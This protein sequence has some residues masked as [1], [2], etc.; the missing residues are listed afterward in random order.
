MK[1]AR[2]LFFL[3][4]GVLAVLSLPGCSTHTCTT[5]TPGSTGSGGGT[6]SGALG[7]H[8]CSGGGGV[9]GGIGVGSALIYVVNGSTASAATLSGNT[10]GLVSPFTP[11]TLSGSGADDMFIVNKKFLYIPQAGS[12]T[13]EGFVISRSSGALTPITGSPFSVPSG[14]DTIASDPQGRFLFVG[15][16]GSGQIATFM[17]DPTTGALTQSPGSPFTYGV[18]SADT[19]AVDGN[20][21]FLYVGQM[22]SAMPLH[23]FSIDQNTGAI[24][25]ITGSP[26][27]LGIS[28]PHADPSGKFLLGVAGFVDEGGASGDNHI[29]VFAIDPVTGTPIAVPGSPFPTASS[30]ADFA[31]SP[32][33]LFVYSF[34]FTSSGTASPIEGFQ[35]DP[36]TGALTSL[37]GSPFVSLP[38]PAQC[39]FDQ[40]GSEM[41]CADSLFGSKLMVFTTN[42]ST[43]ALAHPVTDL[44][45]PSF[46]FAVTN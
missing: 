7:G 12:L 30:P 34:G 29:H 43:G 24:A 22:S 37:Q 16:E 5:I 25:P 26:F 45:T 6:S 20:G 27:P 21:K 14:S 39:K 9:V 31:I 28:T 1:S 19:F 33:G 15:N 35:M 18:S 41:F 36:N 38:T 2:T 23:V 3:M 11:P 17:I 32:N 8:V 42:S 44:T 46:P 10:L 13:V 4:L 40:S